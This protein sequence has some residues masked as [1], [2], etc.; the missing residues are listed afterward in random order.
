MTEPVRDSRQDLLVFPASF[1]QQRLWFLDRL[2]PGSPV[3]NLP[4]RVRLRGHLDRRA[5]ERGLEVIVHRHEALRTTFAAV[6]GE[7]VQVVHPPG[8]V[9]TPLIDLGGL[10]PAEGK[11]E[12]ERIG[13]GDAL[14]PFDLERGPLL[15]CT[16]LR[17]GGSD[18]VLLLSVHHIVWDGW[19]LGVFIRELS[20]LYRATLEGRPAALPELAVQYADYAHWQ[21]RWLQGER[22]ER[23]TAWWCE[24][25]A[26]APAA[27]ELPADRPRPEVQSFRGASERLG[28]DERV[29]ATLRDLARRERSTPFMALLA[30]FAALLA[31]HARQ[32]DVVI[33]TP[34]A[35]R[36]RVELEPLIGFFANSLALRVDCDRRATFRELLGRV[37]EV[38]LEAYS[39]QEVPFENL[40]EALKPER[41]LGQNPLY[42]VVFALEDSPRPGLDLPGLAAI[43][44]PVE[45]GTAKFDLALYME[46]HEGTLCGLL[47]YSRDLFGR[48]T[49][50]RLLRRFATLLGAAAS[51]PECAVSELP[52]LD[53]VERHWLLHAGNDTERVPSRQPFVHRWF[54]VCAA[55]RPDAPAVSQERRTLSYRELDGRANQLAHRLRALGVGPDVP[56]AVAM[57]RSPELIVAM[58]GIFKAGGAYVPLDPAY[59]GDRLAFMLEDSEASVLLTQPHLIGQLP[60]GR[61]V[62]LP[63]GAAWRELAGECTEAPGPELHPDHLAY[64]IYTSGSTGRPKGVMISHRSLASYTETAFRVY[65]IE[66][67]DRVL[68]FCSISFDISIEEII[69]CLARG[70]ELV[71]RT[72]AT[73]ESV[74]I[75]LRACRARSITMLSLPTAYWHDITACLDADGLE[76]PRSLR[77]VIIAGERALP[78]RLAAWLRHAPVRPRLVNTFGLTESTIISTACDLTATKLHDRREVPIGRAIPD[79][80]IY[81]LDGSLEPVPAGVPGEVFLGGRLLA[82]GYLRRPDLTAER[83]LPHPFPESPGT[84]LYATGDLARA[85]ADG[86]L[87]FLGRGDQQ[88]KL[89]GY[90]IELGEIEAALLRLPEVES[91]VVVAREETAGQK[92]VVA[93]VVPARRAA[94]QTGDVRAAL[95]QSLPD[96]MQP[97]ALVVLDALPLTPNGKLDRAALPA[98]DASAAHDSGFVAPRDDMERTIAGVWSEVLGVERVGI[99]DNFFD[100][101]GHSLLLIRIQERLQRALGRAVPML[102]LFRHSTVGALARHF[103]APPPTAS[104]APATALLREKARDRAAR[105]QP[106]AYRERFLEARRRP[107]DGP[108]AGAARAIPA[109]PE[110]ARGPGPEIRIAHA[111]LSRASAAFLDYVLSRPEC[112]ERGSFALLDRQTAFRPFPLQSWPVF[113][114]RSRIEELERVSVGLC[115]LVRSVPRRVFGNDPERV[116]RYYCLD[117]PERARSLLEEPTGIES[118]V[119]RGDFLFSEA[120]LQCLEFNMVSHLGGWQA[121]LWAEAY[122]SVP[123]I[124]DFVRREGLLVACRNT[125]SSLFTHLVSEARRT[126]SLDGHLNVV[127]VVPA[128]LGEDVRRDFAAYLT[129]ELQLLARREGSI[130]RPRV[131]VRTLG[132]LEERQSCLWAGRDRVHVVVEVHDGATAAPVFR[133]FKAG[134]LNLYNAPVRT[135]LTDKR[136]LALLSELAGSDLFSAGERELIEGHVPWTRRLVPDEVTWRGERSWLPELVLSRREEM[137]IKHARAGQG[138][139]VHVGQFTPAE[140]WSVLVAQALEE[141]AWVVQER[142]ESLPLLGQAGER[143]SAPHEAVWGLF[144]FGDTYAGGF[145][146]LRPQGESGVVNVHQGASEGVILELLE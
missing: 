82:R 43:P 39:H 65:A 72:D 3:Y 129:A 66:P 15:R 6:D 37:R 50:A 127:F 52:L 124:A 107:R 5:L 29:T 18:H 11:A 111:R 145:L 91:A 73:L 81:L 121:P 136:N 86:E 2:E 84:R 112:L 113:V 30:A 102:D 51:S 55:E 21:R 53:S 134:T 140:A 92:R 128:D 132:E 108:E 141:D 19:S 110:L 58:L 105:N 116:S 78:E 69:P 62:P 144:V 125:I 17:V 28:I 118:A 59:P 85:L 49:A 47:E 64:V 143:G 133:C 14:Q 89:R 74:P 16:L 12:V 41:N 109:A 120:G 142:I 25:L 38:M 119:G 54:E 71:L 77:L 56:V 75:F 42:Q 27:L 9:R 117:S 93:Y 60:Q 126:L 104:A 106:S 35:N 7:P 137:V 114:D 46:D 95:R 146:S 99:H 98:P 26:G 80:Q 135:L 103:E 63:L 94:L 4:T 13:A 40:V 115:R 79:S 34:T 138:R 88:I 130:L 8:A 20:A 96:Y 33:G 131:A 90:R 36:G 68:Q 22:L 24:R 87:E 101:G 31:R 10:T 48:A 70:G 1:A 76:L 67:S 97:S 122:L 57:E 45:S 100:L 44:L 23:Q 61:A 139:G 32:D 83:F 123:V